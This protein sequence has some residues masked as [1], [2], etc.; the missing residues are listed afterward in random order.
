MGGAM[1]KVVFK[2][3]KDA[4]KTSYTSLNDIPVTDITG[5]E[6]ES[7]GELCKDKKLIL[8]INVASK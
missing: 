7:V 4:F 6:Y 5:K 2:K 3:G 8:I 1:A